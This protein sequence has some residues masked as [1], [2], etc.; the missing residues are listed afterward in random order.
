MVKG[1]FKNL[2]NRNHDHSPS[3][4][5]SIPTSACP[6]YPNKPEKIDSDLKAYL[7]MMVE[8]IKKDF[9]NSLKEIQENTVKEVEVLKEKQKNTTKH[10][11]E[12][13]KTLQDLKT[14][15]ETIKK[16]Q[17]E[18]R[19]E[20]E[21]LGKKSGIIDASISNR[22]QEMEERISGAEDSTENVGTTIKENAKYKK[23]LTQNIQ[24]IQDTMR[25]PNLRIIGVD[26]NEDFQLKGPANIFNKIIEENIPNLKRCP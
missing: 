19:L 22:I 2:T 9:N 5:P 10:V 4:E 26:E 7:M 21:T 23:I 25:R 14:E 18:K 24:E 1:K 8:D 20:L 17:S 11:M 13:N 12:L 16:T 6:G 15:V 3:S